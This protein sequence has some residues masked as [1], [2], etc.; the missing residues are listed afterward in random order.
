MKFTSLLFIPTLLVILAKECH[1]EED[2]VLETVSLEEPSQDILT[3]RRLS[4]IDSLADPA[5]ERLDLFPAL[6]TF[7]RVMRMINRRDALHRVKE[8]AEKLVI[9]RGQSTSPMTSLTATAS[10]FKKLTMLRRLISIVGNRDHS[11]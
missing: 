5:S 1:S 2:A 10:K 6:R 3:P 11:E 4:I 9:R 8:A 7:I